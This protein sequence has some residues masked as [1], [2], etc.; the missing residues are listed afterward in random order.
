MS[1]L[2]CEIQIFKE[3]QIFYF[4][5]FLYLTLLKFK[6]KREGNISQWYII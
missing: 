5:I 4:I 6:T 3:V 2:K 1:G